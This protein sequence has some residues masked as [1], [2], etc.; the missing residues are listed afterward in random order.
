MQDPLPLHRPHLGSANLV[1]IRIGQRY[2]I[3][4]LIAQGGTSIIYRAQDVELGR[5]VALKI[6]RAPRV[7]VSPVNEERIQRFQREGR[8]LARLKHSNIVTVYD[9]GVDQSLADDDIYYIAM[10]FMEGETLEQ[11][12]DRLEAEEKQMPWEEI[13]QIVQDVAAALDYA[14]SHEL[15]FVHR[16]VTPSNIMLRDGRA[17]LFDFG[18]LKAR[19]V[20]AGTAGRGSLSNFGTLTQEGVA[21]GT[22][23]YWS[24][25]QIVGAEVDERTDVYALGGVLFRMLTGRLPYVGE[26]FFVISRQHLQDP[27]PQ[28][29]AIDRGLF[30]FDTIVVRAMAKEPAGRY[31]SAGELAAAVVDALHLATDPLMGRRLSVAQRFVGRLYTALRVAVMVLAVAVFVLG[32]GV[33][34]GN[35]FRPQVSLPLGWR[36]ATQG[37]TMDRVGPRE[38]ELTVQGRHISYAVVQEGSRLAEP[39]ISMDVELI[40]G[41]AETAYGIAFQ[42]LDEDNYYVL[43]M[44]GNG[45]VGLWQRRDGEW[46]IPVP[47][48]EG[49]I[50]RK[51]VG[52]GGADRLEVTI[53][54]GR[55]VGKVNNQPEFD[56]QLDAPQAGYVGAFVS[57][58]RETLN[59]RATIR[60]DLYA[61]R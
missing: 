61:R 46:R 24:P 53:D 14:H 21:M 34:Y 7:F 33:R 25:E 60:F 20:A 23:A 9:A 22:P 5:T 1:G 38:Y 51:Y 41:P 42:Y 27:P 56:I 59:A 35:W 45:Q 40:D 13:A 19:N 12:L 26:D 15:G 58:S 3:R 52:L 32:M 39:D 2:V 31:A 50:E 54:D 47:E 28:P 43:A 30:A 11:R 57:T 4:E 16:D 36:S 8:A 10:E 48:R 49:W 55:A 6:I 37:V 18:L 17:Y 44:T 29:S